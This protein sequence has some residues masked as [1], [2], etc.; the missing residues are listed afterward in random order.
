GVITPDDA[1]IALSWSG[2]NAELRDLTDYAKRFRVALIAVTASADS[3]LA[4]ADAIALVLP[5]ATEACPLG[6][7]PT[8]STLMQLALGD[9]LAVALFESRGFTAL[10][11][12]DFHPVGKLGASLTFVRDVMHEGAALPLVAQGTRMSGAIVEMSG[13]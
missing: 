13:K 10:Q 2:E 5:A 7:A 1:I 6:P 9:A 8:T 4:R 11:F 12:R 3:A